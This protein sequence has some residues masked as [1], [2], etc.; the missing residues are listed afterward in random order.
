ML[1]EIAKDIIRKNYHTP[2]KIM[3]DYDMKE[4]D[5]PD[6]YGAVATG[7][8]LAIESAGDD[9]E[10]FAD[11]DERY[12]EQLILPYVFYECC[13]ERPPY[14]VIPKMLAMYEDLTDSQRA[15]V[16]DIVSARGTDGAVIN[17]I[18]GI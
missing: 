9:A 4:T 1:T 16:D 6:W 5:I 8:C 7:F 3:K 10:A 12:I 2:E 13:C 18:L 17:Y 11:A 15:A 14:L